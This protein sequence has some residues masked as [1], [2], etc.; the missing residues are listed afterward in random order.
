M[1]SKR[2][3]LTF[4]ALMTV[5]SAAHAQHSSGSIVGTAVT[6]DVIDVKGSDTGFHRELKIDEDGKF[7]LRSVPVGSYIVTVT[8]ADGTTTESSVEVRVGSAARV[9]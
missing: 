9:K 1:S 2:I 5:A 6:G 7:Q 8:H 3:A 4:A